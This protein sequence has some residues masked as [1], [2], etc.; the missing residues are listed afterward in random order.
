MLRKRT[1]PWG[2]FRVI[3]INIDVDVGR[4]VRNA[5]YDASSALEASMWHIYSPNASA[6]LGGDGGDVSVTFSRILP[7]DATLV[8]NAPDVVT[9]R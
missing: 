2:S 5:E 4:G 8:W 7:F 1:S 3:S 9:P 6:I